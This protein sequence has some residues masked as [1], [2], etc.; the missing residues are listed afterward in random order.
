MSFHIPDINKITKFFAIF[1]ALSVFCLNGYGQSA[2]DYRT[3]ATGT[4]D[5]S[6][7]GNWQRYNGTAWAAPGANGY[8]GQNAGTGTVTIRN[9]HNVTLNVSP[10]NNIGTLTIDPGANATALT[11]GAFTLNVT[12][13]VNVNSNTNGIAKSIA[14]NTGTLSCNNL[15]LTGSGGNDTRD[16]FVVLTSGTLNVT[17]NITM[18]AA[19]TKTYIR[20]NGGGTVN[21]GGTITGGNITSTNGGGTAAPTGG[22]VNYNNS[23]NQSIG[24]YGYWTLTTSVSGTKTLQANTT[25]QNLQIGGTSILDAREFQITGNA[26]GN[27]T[28]GAGT[29]L[30][31][32]APGNTNNISFPSAFAAGSINLNTT[33]TVTY[34]ANANQTV[35]GVPTYGNLIIL[36]GNTANRTRTLGAATVINGNLTVQG[37]A[38]LAT[39]NFG[40]TLRGDFINNGTFTEATGTVT[41]NGTSLQSLGG[42]TNTSFYNLTVSNAAGVTLS[43]G[44]TVSNTLNLATG[45]LSLG[46]GTNNLTIG[47]TGTITG[48]FD[49]NHMVVCDG[50]GS[51][52]KQ[53]TTSAG[54]VGVFPVGT[55]TYYTP[56][57]ITSL[58]ATIAGTGSITVRA[59]AG[60]APGPPPASSTD[61]QK[62]WVVTTPNVSVT[63][64]GLGF[65]Y[66][67]PGEVGV[68]GDQSAYQPYLYSGGAWSIPAGTSAG[69][70]NPMTVTGATAIEGT[71]TGREATKTYYSY[72]SGS[73][74]TA[75]TW[76]TDPSGTLSV[77][78]GI[79]GPMDRVV[80]LNGRT[81]TTSSGYTVLSTQINDGGTLDI[82]NTAGHNL[83]DVRGMGRL[84]LSTMTFP[85]GIFTGF[86][87]ING[88]SVEYYDISGTFVQ[89][90][91]NNLILQKTTNSAANYTMTA[92]TNLIINGDLTLNRVQGSGTVALTVGNSATVRNIIINGDLL[93]NE[94]CSIATNNANAIHTLS[95]GGDFTNNG[96]VR[97]TNQAAPN[98]TSATTT[99][100]VVVSFLKVADSFVMCN[101]Q[102][103]FYRIII[104]KGIDDTYILNLEASAAANF[105]LFGPCNFSDPSTNYAL[106]LQKGTVRIGPYINIQLA[107][108]T[109]YMVYAGCRLWVDGGTVTVPENCNQLGITGT[110]RITSGTAN[111]L[112]TGGIH[113]NAVG[114]AILVDGG[115]LNA[116]VMRS[117]VTAGDQ[118]G[119]F[120]QKGGAVLLSGP[121]PGNNFGRLSWWRP[122]NRFIMSGGTLTVQTAGNNNDG[123]DI[124]SLPENISITGGTII[125][126]ISDGRDFKINSRAPFW[127]LQLI[128][129]GGA[130]G[131]FIL[132]DFT[133]GAGTSIGA[134]P[135][136]VYRNLS[137]GV[138]LSSSAVT[139]TTNSSNVTVAGDFIIGT[140][141]VYT[142]GNNTTRFNGTAGQLFQIDG[143]IGGGLQNLEI[144]NSSN[145]TITTSTAV[146]G[147]LTI[148]SKCF[149]N[150]Q[151][152]TLSVAGNITNSGT[153]RSQ[154]GGSLTL[155]GTGAQSISG[156][157]NGIFGN[158]HIN[159]A[160][161]PVS[162]TANQTLTGNLRLVNGLLNIGPYALS[163][164]SGS[165]VY[166][167]ATGTATAF[168]GTKMIST[169]GNM[170]D[171]GMTKEYS[172]TTAFTFPLGTAAD[173]TP[174]TIQFTS[175][176]ATWG[177]VNVKPVA[178]AN[179]F[180][181][182][183]SSLN[184]YWKVTQTGF[185]GIVA[186]SVSHT[187]RY[188]DSD[189]RPDVGTEPSYIPGVYN[190]FSWVFINDVS[191]VVDGSNDIRFNNVSYVNGD[192]TAGILAAFSPVTV[193]YSRTSGNWNSSDTWSNTA[194]GGPACPAGTTPGIN[195]PGATN[196]VV[197]GDGGSNNHIVTIPSTYNNVIVGGLQISPGSTLDITTSTGHNLGSI[198][199][200]KVSGTGLL[201]ISSGVT[202]A[203]FPGGDF[204]N[205]LSA[206]GGTVEY[207]TS[208]TAFT[209]PSGKTSYNYLVVS[210]DAQAITMP[211]I[212]LIIYGDF[213][214]NGAGT[215]YLN[216]TTPRTLAV[217][218]NIDINGGTLQ[219]FNGT[220]QTVN[221]NNDINISAGTFNVWSAGI[222]VANRLNISGSLNNN[223][224]FAMQ[225]GTQ[226]CNVYFTGDSDKVIA[227][228]GT[229]TFN[230]LNV[231]KGSSRNTILDVTANNMS[232]LGIG[233]ALV[234]NNGTFRVSNS[235]LD[236]TLST[237]TTFTIPTTAALSV[238]RGKV[239]IG[240]SSSTG[241]L[242]LAGRLEIINTGTVNIGNGGNFNNDIEYASGESPEIVVS[243]TGILNV[244]GQI[245][246]G[247]TVT[248]GS[249]SYV[250]TG[251][252]VNI[253][254]RA[255]NT[256]RAMFEII[257]PESSFSMS[258][259][260]ITVVNGGN[261]TA[262]FGDIL[263]T[264][265]TGAVTGGIIQVGSDATIAGGNQTFHISSNIPLWDLVIDASSRTKTTNL[266]VFPL[267]LQ[268]NLTINGNSE[269]RANG[270]GVTIAGSLYNNNGN[271]ATGVSAGGYQAGSLTQV[272]TF[273]GSGSQYITGTGGN[274][275]NFANLVIAGNSLT[276]SSNSNIRVNSDLIIQSGSF[277][278]GSND[279]TVLGNI[280]NS[281]THTSP[282]AT[283]GIILAGPNKQTVS[284]DGSG[285]FGNVTVSNSLGVDMTDNCII[286]GRLEFT[287]GLLYINDYLLT[288]GSGATIAGTTGVTRMIILNGVLS[289]AGVRKNFSTGASDFTFPIGVAGKYTPVRYTFSSND[290]SNASVTIKP[291]NASHPFMFN[292]DGDELKYYW[293]TVSNGF[294]LP[295]TVSHVYNY[296]ENDVLG[297]ENNYVGGR[298]IAGSW[299]PVGGLA[300]AVEAVND[301]IN[302][303]GVNYLDGEYT[304]GEAA[305]FSN[306]PVL[307]SR[308]TGNW[309]DANTWS[310]TPGGLSCSCTPDGNP[311]VIA[312]AHTVTIDNNGAFVYS[313]D[314]EGT[315]NAGTTVFH[316]LG[317]VS[318]SGTIRLTATPDNMFVFPGGEFDSFISNPQSTIEFFSDNNATLP[319]KPG[320]KYKPYQNVRFTGAGIK[321]ISAEDMKVMGNL[322]IEANAI[323]SN[324]LFNRELTI[325]GNWTD[326]NT[327]ATGGFVPGTGNVIFNG[328]GG[329]FLIVTGALT[330][331]RFYNLQI[332]NA[333]GM[334]ISGGGSAAVSNKL[335]LTLGNI[336][337]TDD[338]LLSITNTSPLA[339]AGGGSSSFVNGPLL[340]RISSGSY[341]D[342]PV[343]NGNSTKYGNL[344]ISDVSLSGDYIAQYY[345]H[346]PATDGFNPASVINPVDA[347]SNVEYWRF[348]G[349]AGAA[350]NVRVRWD[351]D[352]GII[353]ADAASRTKLR[354]VEW[355]GSAW[356]NR[357]DVI[358]DG[359]QSSGTIRT[360]SAIQVDS[361]H[362]FTIGSESLPTAIITSGN[363][364]I[365]N[366]GSSA[367]IIIALTGT[368][369][370]TIKYKVNGANETT[371]GNIASSP[372]TL[373]VSNE[374]EPLATLGP[375]AYVFN[376]SYISDASGSTG[377]RDFST[378]VTVTLNESPD[379]VISGNTTV[380]IG[381]TGVVYSSGTGTIPGH[382]YSWAVSPGATITSGQGTYMITVSWPSSSGSGWVSLQETVT[383]GGCTVTT[384]NYVVAITDIPN[385]DVTG[386]SPVC[387]N[388]TYTYTTPLVGTHSYSW[389]L[390][391]GGGTITG[392]ANSNSVT[393]N[394]TSTGNYIIRVTETGS[395][396][397]TDDLAVS[398]NPIP[399]SDNVVS[400][401]SIC[402]SGIASIQI[403]GTAP[404]LSFQL[405]LN[406][407]NT[408]VGLPV[409]SGPG[410]D[411]TI[412]VKSCQH[413]NL[414]RT[415]H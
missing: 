374:M 212:N 127:N 41:F 122:E 189:I 222:A 268:N 411:I 205:F 131:N 207:Y 22:T 92:G 256:I 158:L 76:T 391:S 45:N 389:S 187:Y 251:G 123:I 225:N 271:A 49:N 32:G 387:L 16:A 20:F 364:S 325:V 378:T 350:A 340:K 159:N 388:G 30:I 188:V 136:V 358:N 60:A 383:T 83:G 186:N 414:Q 204:G 408:T 355:T 224:I 14:L 35:S 107:E 18:S 128:R 194:V 339:V 153:H 106:S 5:W 301:R 399:A 183:G 407:D 174:A 247:L 282:T 155:S 50:S 344:Y 404:G 177:S 216:Y 283:G 310:E 156:D 257:N 329:Q 132:T 121:M 260:K 259:G 93:V 345:N 190:P 361:D 37:S 277:N 362:Y 313:V 87:S 211:D 77:N 380:G 175:A 347:V 371:I 293:N 166:S 219:Y 359:G 236:F 348:N 197:I 74:G 237:N 46:S 84:R 125:A 272:A 209:L 185:T 406:S 392:P 372:Y 168:S 356:Q 89:T 25:V 137:M 130:A 288:L 85:A 112:G 315:L 234:L 191:Q 357:G 148:N 243:G 360:N 119:T 94:G 129:T 86:V 55:G 139:L 10:A 57:E 233:T 162:F 290:N 111:C 3:N 280:S 172:S 143:T 341:F 338:N 317:H 203:A 201:R 124:R 100:A 135:L 99:G 213:T 278:D 285:I 275:T 40:L 146:N 413:I 398:V 336:T 53:S 330:T 397:R 369:P 239:T 43:G 75:A 217:E 48:N 261:G 196:P 19:G 200:S 61:L 12:G 381:E 4:W 170:S 115:T 208:G 240:T 214:K 97:F 220:E 105:R 102:T 167:A 33:S 249:L 147:N 110:F 373:V 242:I 38:T 308:Q 403:L 165:N 27:M 98:Y 1:A 113:L 235:L 269:F 232:L 287:N 273:N 281:A 118:L 68:G 302:L 195:I 353:P 101:S 376:V 266:R 337:T 142:P 176:P 248:T 126:Q 133:S 169:A 184:Y 254:G 367:D 375:G 365:C 47:A 179:P 24:A 321:Y 95:I 23:G 346:N 276:L 368:A 382:S 363:V 409:L 218:G 320:N 270:L 262:S 163:L 307:Y 226:Y 138:D 286:N 241:D 252:E 13:D 88:G 15:F 370:W 384:A 230:I 223:G 178:Q 164:G 316:N 120:Q 58:N 238:N 255:A 114:G 351:E 395:A 215:A 71:W 151:G 181:T 59:V 66:N 144:I 134:Q 8:P 304:A 149:L 379:P 326:N 401:P 284:G 198:P 314:I 199:D 265:E 21:V 17:G 298:F 279:I 402:G 26:A 91:Y 229:N 161:G 306:M 78:P 173:Y 206:G 322:T 221:V 264:P 410:G 64:A 324:A 342:F 82:G 311:V 228:T 333:A 2:G 294:S 51:L 109:Q 210:P 327:S 180:V 193:F 67:N 267:V 171:G 312:A 386:P 309:F 303:S 331:E 377:V 36:P 393:V 62:Y 140:G 305:N 318:G 299:T 152:S 227:G 141:S 90:D 231:D 42:S 116:R 323:L 11:F 154:A 56:F 7:T 366:D 349:T 332:N 250:Q 103:D 108:G 274:L 79:P 65:T 28:M 296:S 354:I 80:I 72:Q 29:G 9:N 31:L 300:G 192:Y 343:G 246:R 104:N 319:L 54:L 81:V 291:V 292:A 328:N 390:P 253:A 150:D 295:F 258:G 394:W 160:A 297:N 182:S 44:I 385:P 157:G 245:R 145:T 405:R 202:P 96:T 263:I 412:N 396:P 334:I 335:Y 69:G 34:T 70:A 415:C 289:D 400:D 117:S 352:S 6:T 73:W 52:I 63:S 39:N 244:N